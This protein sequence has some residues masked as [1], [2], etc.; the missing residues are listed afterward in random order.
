MK[1]NSMD[2][3]DLVSLEFGVPGS[4]QHDWYQGQHQK[5][6]HNYMYV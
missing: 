1:A 4:S 2:L 6:A 3:S 5:I